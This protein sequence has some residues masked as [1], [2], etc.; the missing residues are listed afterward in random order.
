MSEPRDLLG[1][2]GRHL[3]QFRVGA[4]VS[5]APSGLLYA[6]RDLANEMKSVWLQ[7]FDARPA[8]DVDALR[9]QADAWASFDHPLVSKIIGFEAQPDAPPFVAVE[10]CDGSL[11]AEK[12]SSG[13]LP[14]VEAV[15]LV[16]ALG[17][18]LSAAHDRGLRHFGISEESVVVPKY[19]GERPRLFGFGL[20]CG[21]ARADLRGWHYLAPEHLTATSEC[22]QRVDVYAL[23][24]LLYRAATG[25]FLIDLPSGATTQ[26]IA[27][28]LIFGERQDPRPSL[29][30]PLE[31]LAALI[32]KATHPDRTKRHQNVGEL[33]AELR[34]A[35]VLLPEVER[36]QSEKHVVPLAAPPSASPEIRADAEAKTASR[37]LSEVAPVS[38]QPTRQARLNVNVPVA[39]QAKSTAPFAALVIEEQADPLIGLTVNGLEFKSKVA[40]GG[41]GAV[42]LVKNTTLGRTGAVKVA[43]L[44]RSM[45]AEERFKQEWTI[46][47]SLKE[48]HVQRVIQVYDVGKL[49]DG[50]PYVE[51]EYVPGKSLS[52]VIEAEKKLPVYRALKIANSLAETLERAHSLGIIHRDVKPSNI[53]MEESGGPQSHKLRLIDWGIA[54]GTGE[55]KLVHTQADAQAGTPGYMSPQAITNS[56]VDG[57]ADVYSLAV[58]LFEMLT[59]E[60]PITG[61]ETRSVLDAT[62]FDEP[63]RL[64]NLRPELPS[65]I[66]DLI[67]ASLVKKQDDRP[68]MAEF[69]MRLFS[70]L[71]FLDKRRLDGGGKVSPIGTQL[72][73]GTPVVL[74]FHKRPTAAVPVRE[75]EE[76]LERFARAKQRRRVQ[77]AA[78]VVAVAALMLVMVAGLWMVAKR[79][80]IASP[81]AIA[82]EPSPQPIHAEQPRSTLAWA[83]G[84]PA[85][86][87]A[88]VRIGRVRIVTTP[89]GA[90]VRV[91]SEV[92]GAAPVEVTGSIDKLLRVRLDLAGY[93]SRSEDVVPTREGGDA[94]FALQRPVAGAHQRATGGRHRQ[95]TPTPKPSKSDSA[96]A[97]PRLDQNPNALAPLSGET[98]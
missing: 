40:E 76:F 71:T 12:L 10:K 37:H 84:N 26:Q 79:Q 3:G 33:V 81:R 47:I 52:H 54:R 49:P 64:S 16:V 6:G 1:V 83:T 30:A 50:R 24:V 61:T 8:K 43:F 13:P 23:G 66:G 88:V 63:R 94:V 56:P 60:L 19:A 65:A 62:L 38:S 89:A 5:G 39:I 11:L 55:V 93:V 96:I 25:R 92:I 20:P 31:P 28:A 72:S 17:E 57:R 95:E 51:M 87:A 2:E 42:Y 29:P 73:G 46:M 78:V 85:T 75:H 91:N 53:I 77:I 4:V 58:T 97:A 86:A 48:A 68:T 35:G 74:P 59:G 21:F 44:G 34:G 22:D 67:A 18:V 70:I 45:T 36:E 27:G 15:Q 32:E 69:R 80:A 14:P 9:R 7:F 82:T 41:M 90:S 98:P